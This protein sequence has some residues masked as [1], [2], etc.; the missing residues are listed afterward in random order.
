L[1]LEK[2]VGRGRVEFFRAL[3]K[4]L[5]R[6]K[7]GEEIFFGRGH[8]CFLEDPKE[9]IVGFRGARAASAAAEVMKAVGVLPLPPYIRRPATAADRRR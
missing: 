4:P 6:L 9:K 8:S 7:T 2:L 3:I 5:G 1:L